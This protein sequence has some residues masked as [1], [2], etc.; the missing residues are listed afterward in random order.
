M[1]HVVSHVM[2]CHA[3]CCVMRHVVSYVMFVNLCMFLIRSE[4]ND[5]AL[6]IAREV[7]G[8]TVVIALQQLVHSCY[9]YGTYPFTPL[10]MPCLLSNYIPSPTPFSAYHGHLGSLLAIS[11]VKNFPTSQE[12]D[13]LIVCEAGTAL[14]L[15][16]LCAMYTV[17]GPPPP[18]PSRPPVPIPTV[19]NIVIQ[20]LQAT[21]MPWK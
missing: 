10:A 6:R 11:T 19:G 14:P 12:E 7:T 16:P 18:A 13:V 15:V 4:A 9:T 21:C 20:R 8:G 5:M 3:S 1:R 2:L 17:C